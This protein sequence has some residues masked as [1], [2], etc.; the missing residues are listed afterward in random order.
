MATVELYEWRVGTETIRETSAWWSQTKDGQT[1]TPVSGLSRSA[2]DFSTSLDAAK[3]TITVHRA[4]E[5]ALRYRTLPPDGVTLTI[6]RGSGST[7]ERIWSGRL[8]AVRWRADEAQLELEP[9]QTALRLR[10]LQQTYSPHCR[11][12]LADARCGIGVHDHHLVH[13]ELYPLR[14]DLAVAAVDGAEVTI[15][16]LSDFVDGAIAHHPVN[17]PVWFVGGEMIHDATDRRRFILAHSGDVVTLQAHMPDVTVG[18]S[19]RLRAGCNH[20]I[21]VCRVKFANLPQFGGFAFTPLRN[22]FVTKDGA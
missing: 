9:P 14:V 18:D 8:S 11:H 3:L 7:W 15:T 20:S 16:G 12:R 17:G 2:L 1:Y 5:I 22:P 21:Q 6:W 4:H 13:P 19:V 10:G